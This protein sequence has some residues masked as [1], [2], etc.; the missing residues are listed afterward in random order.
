V[1]LALSALAAAEGALSTGVKTQAIEK[2]GIKA[3]K[4]DFGKA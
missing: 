3:W 2:C 1:I 4:P